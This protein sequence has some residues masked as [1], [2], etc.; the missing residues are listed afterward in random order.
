MRVSDV[1]DVRLDPRFRP[2]DKSG[3][4]TKPWTYKLDYGGYIDFP[5]CRD[6]PSYIL[7]FD[8]KE[9][10]EQSRLEAQREHD[11]NES[12]H[13]FMVETWGSSNSYKF[14]K[15][16]RDPVNA[17][18]YILANAR[19]QPHR[20]TFEYT[21]GVNNAG[22]LFGGGNYSGF[23]FRIV[24]IEDDVLY[25]ISVGGFDSTKTFAMIKPDATHR[26]LQGRMMMYI[27]LWG[28]KVLKTVQ[29]RLTRAEAEWLYREHRGREYFEPNIEFILSGEVVL[30]MLENTNAVHSFRALM[31]PTDRTKA[32]GHTLRAK[33]AVGY[34]ENS[35]HGS[36]SDESA[37]MELKYFFGD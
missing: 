11:F 1:F 18:R 32:E 25:P 24:K 30:M 4:L 9:E 13:M 28:F 7:S 29:R 12:S 15:L 10:A 31:G 26:R 37:A 5:K 27:Q 22:R 8:T 20:P 33:F 35:I 34:R 17:H 36:D 2:H 23:N 6:D 19:S 21:Y 16:F 3:E 14:Q